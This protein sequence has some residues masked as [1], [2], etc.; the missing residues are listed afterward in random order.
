MEAFGSE[1][2]AEPNL[3]MV[4]P[5]VL[6]PSIEHMRV[7]EFDDTL[8]LY[9]LFGSDK[10][11]V[12]IGGLEADVLDWSPD[13]LMVKLDRTG[14]KSKGE[15]VVDSKG[16]LSNVRRIT[17]WIVPIN[18]TLMFPDNE[19]L[20]ITGL[21][22]LRFRADVGEYREEA[23]GDIIKPIRTA[24]ITRDSGADLVATGPGIK[25]TEDEHCYTTWEGQGT[26]EPAGFGATDLI[27]GARLKVNTETRKGYIGLEFGGLA[28]SPFSIHSVCEA[29]VDPDGNVI[30]GSEGR[31]PLPLT[32][33]LLHGQQSFEDPADPRNPAIPLFAINFDFQSDYR[34]PAGVFEDVDLGL[35]LDW[36]A[37]NP[38]SPPDP[39]AP[40]SANVG[41][42]PARR[43][44]VIGRRKP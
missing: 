41:E 31:N 2:V 19:P 43:H 4:Q 32:F 39:Q 29:F 15:V 26:F 44:R 42:A 11:V 23:H 38:S 1:L 3:Q 16:R 10:P 21:V 35:R 7:I 5:I 36:T 6:T 30:P 33:G 24:V 27:L 12:K 37:V 34:I 17:E 25:R 9:G 13:R 40:R 14:A 28:P 18:Y 8:V 20:K 22:A